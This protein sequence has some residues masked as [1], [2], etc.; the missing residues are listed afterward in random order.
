MIH[1]FNRRELSITFQLKEQARMREILASHQ[2]EY[3][4]KTKN[5]ANS[6]LRSVSGTFGLNSDAMYE[7]IIYVKKADYKRALYLIRK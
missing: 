3:T 1:I 5:M 7:Y 4:V 6:A 2:I